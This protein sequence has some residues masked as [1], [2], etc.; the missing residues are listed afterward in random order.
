MNNYKKPRLKRLLSEIQEGVAPSTWWDFD[1]AGHNDEAQKETAALIG[2]K[3]FSTPKPVRL[4]K[5]ILNLE[6]GDSDIVLDFFSGSATTAQAVLELNREDGVNRRF[7]L[8]QLLEPTGDKKLPTI[9]EIGKERIRRVIAEINAGTGNLTGTEP[10][11]LGFKVYKLAE[12]NFNLWAGVPEWTPAAYQRQLRL[13]A[14]EPLRA[15]WTANGLLW[16]VAVKEGYGLT[17]TIEPVADV[18][19]TVYKVADAEKGQHFLACLDETMPADIAKQ[20]GLTTNDLFVVRDLALDDT[21]ASN[22]ALQCRLKVI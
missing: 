2:N 5:K 11:D 12:S 18:S 4:L 22:L 13:I 10:E 17:S 16:E 20:L 6:I 14:E 19:G 9:A 7:I 3:V 8:V 21:L 1:S 15:G